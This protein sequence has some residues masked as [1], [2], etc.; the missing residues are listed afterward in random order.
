MYS[1]AQYTELD[2][3]PPLVSH[4]YRVD[5]WGTCLARGEQP[6]PADFRVE[7]AGE[8]AAAVW[9]GMLQ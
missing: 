2:L 1:G 4:L 3:T 5:V 8:V 6:G 9:V 7:A